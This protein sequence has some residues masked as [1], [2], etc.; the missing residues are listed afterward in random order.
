R[1]GPARRF[2]RDG[3]RRERSLVAG[4]RRPGGGAES[5]PVGR[6]AGSLLGAGDAFAHLLASGCQAAPRAE[7]FAVQLEIVP[8]LELLKLGR[9]SR[10]FQKPNVELVDED[11]RI[12]EGSHDCTIHSTSMPG[13]IP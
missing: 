1:T 4:S 7:M 10:T 6:G 12:N 8:K 3:A 2:L 5:L 11:V 9:K 13:L